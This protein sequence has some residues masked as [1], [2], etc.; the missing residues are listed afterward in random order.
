MNK[1]SGLLLNL[2][3]GIA[4]AYIGGFLSGAVG[5]SAT[6]IV[7]ELIVATIGAVVLLWVI[8]RLKKA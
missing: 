8:A 5:L 1:S 3:V 7:G 6:G 2:L 4:G